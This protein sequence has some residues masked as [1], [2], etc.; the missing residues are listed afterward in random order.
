MTT[1]KQIWLWILF[2]IV[3][4]PRHQKHYLFFGK[5]GKLE[6]QDENQQGYLQGQRGGGQNLSIIDA[7]FSGIQWQVLFELG[8]LHM[9]QSTES[10]RQMVQRRLLLKFSTKC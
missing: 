8:T 7:R 1:N 10:M 4:F 3:A 9:L 6:L 2:T 5:N